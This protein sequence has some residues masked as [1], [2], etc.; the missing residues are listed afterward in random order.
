MPMWLEIQ[1]LLMLTYAGGL[2]I[3][4]LLWARSAG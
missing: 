2:A 3:G 1:V 4:W